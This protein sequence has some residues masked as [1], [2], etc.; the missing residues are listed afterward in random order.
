VFEESLARA[1]GKSNSIANTQHKI[2]VFADP[3]EEQKK[4]EEYWNRTED[5][6]KAITGQSISSK[7]VYSNKVSE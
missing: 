5:E 2:Q 7:I 6:W 3:S 1:R 4:F